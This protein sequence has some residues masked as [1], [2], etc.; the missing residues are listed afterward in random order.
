YFKDSNSINYLVSQLKEQIEHN[1]GNIESL[2]VAAVINRASMRDEELQE[3]KELI[4]F[5]V[6][7]STDNVAVHNMIFYDPD[8]PTVPVITPEPGIIAG[9]ELRDILIYGG[10]ALA[11]LAILSLIL[12]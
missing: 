12:T 1:P 11:V 10:I 5:A 3:I 7:M 2:T 4:A 9:L 8:E 6:G